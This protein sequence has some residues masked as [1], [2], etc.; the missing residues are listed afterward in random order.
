[1]AH[2]GAGVAGAVRFGGEAS[3]R[4]AE[5]PSD[6][7][8]D[9]VAAQARD[10][11]GRE[12]ELAQ[13]LVGVLTHVGRGGPDRGGRARQRGRWRLER[14]REP[15]ASPARPGP[16]GARSARSHMAG[17]SG[18]GPR[19]RL[20]IE[21][22]PNRRSLLAEHA[23]E[24]PRGSSTDPW[25]SGSADRRSAPRSPAPRRD[26][27]RLLPRGGD[28]DVPILGREDAGGDAG[29]VVI[30]GGG[31]ISL[32]MSHRAAWKSSHHGL[33]QRGVHPLSAPPALAL[34]DRGEDALGQEDAAGE[35][36]RGCRRAPGPSRDRHEPPQARAIWS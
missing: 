1:M 19:A 18:W 13:D 31:G 32:P 11:V 28:I 7:L 20:G 9:F 24:G 6:L 22:L 23:V 2:S 5:A 33:Q 4:A 12:S 15:G 14:R 34:D 16:S 26:G 3:E 10:V 30:A 36:P 35:R 21:Q 8:D 25:T 29:G 17:R 27:G